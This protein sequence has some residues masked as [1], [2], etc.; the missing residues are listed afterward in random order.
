M[1]ATYYG[2][3]NP[4]HSVVPCYSLD[5]SDAGADHVTLY[6]YAQKVA[7]VFGFDQD[8]VTPVP[9]ALFPQLSPRPKDTSFVTDKMERELACVLL[10]WP[11]DWP[12]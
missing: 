5:V 10:V 6:Q 7:E 9:S 12:A 3:R 4:G 8:L 1:V 11:R 2:E